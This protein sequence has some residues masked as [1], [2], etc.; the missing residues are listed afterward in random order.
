MAVAIQNAGSFLPDPSNPG[1]E[2][3]AADRSVDQVIDAL[4]GAFAGNMTEYYEAES[5]VMSM[6]F[7]PKEKKGQE[8]QAA[9]AGETRATG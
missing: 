8:A 9:P 5:K 4:I 1:G 7:P 3:K 6:N 2:F